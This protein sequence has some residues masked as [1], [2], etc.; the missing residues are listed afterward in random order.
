[1]RRG[2][3]IEQIGE[4]AFANAWRTA[5]HK[6]TTLR[7]TRVT[8]VQNGTASYV[9][10][11]VQGKLYGFASTEQHYS[12]SGIDKVPETMAQDDRVLYQRDILA[13]NGSV[14]FDEQIFVDQTTGAKTYHAAVD[15]W[16]SNK[17]QD[18]TEEGIRALPGRGPY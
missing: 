7:G 5:S 3:N 12:L 10:I 1:M 13:A 9:N 15:W 6:A 4:L 2:K 8:N 11:P 16:H 14:V 17:L 18:F